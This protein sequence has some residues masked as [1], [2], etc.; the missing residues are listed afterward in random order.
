MEDEKRGEQFDEFPPDFVQSRER[1]KRSNK[2]KVAMGCGVAVLAVLGLGFIGTIMGDPYETAANET[3]SNAGAPIAKALPE[4]QPIR[5]TSRVVAEYPPI[6]DVELDAGDVRSPE[7]IG[8]VGDAVLK[9]GR[10]SLDGQ[11]LAS[12]KIDAFNFTVLGGV[13]TDTAVGRKIVHFTISRGNLEK[14][15]QANASGTTVL[16]RATDAGSWSPNNR[17]VIEPFCNPRPQSAFCA[18]V[19]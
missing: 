2:N 4:D 5:I 13:G 11:P 6:L 17:D 9:I 18:M 15:V 8:S 1:P 14:L 3:A 10:D 12:G 7:V 16:D 19:R